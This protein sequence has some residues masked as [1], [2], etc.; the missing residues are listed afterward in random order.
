MIEAYKIIAKNITKHI[1]DNIGNNNHS[2]NI[3]KNGSL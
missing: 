1:N 3:L 2:H